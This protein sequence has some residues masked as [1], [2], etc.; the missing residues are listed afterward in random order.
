M[1][2]VVAYQEFKGNDK[3][4]INSE[5]EKLI[6]ELKTNYNA[7]LLSLDEEEGELYTK[8]GE[9]KV[10]FDSFL[11][12]IK[13]CLKYGVDLDVVEPSKL[14]ISSK[15]F[16]EAIAHIIDFFR[17]FC[18]KYGVMFNVYVR[19]EKEFELDKYKEGIYDEDDIFAFQDEDSLLR[20][21]AVFEGEGKSE[22]DIVKKI[23]MSLNEEML[24][25]KIITKEIDDSKEGFHGLIAVEIFCK[26]FDVVELAYKF[27]P[28]TISIENKDIEIDALELQDIGNDLGGAVFELSHAAATMK[29]K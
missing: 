8:V 6:E 16:G 23:L 12:Y 22:E 24:V 21:K 9:L 27:L 2:E 3:E 1:I 4:I 10:K 13:F 5:F 26:P 14:K 18:N 29:K 20:I 28:V 25:N 15:E 11:D 19:E 7:E 17:I